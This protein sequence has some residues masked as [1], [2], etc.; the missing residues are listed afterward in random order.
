MDM[1]DN[2]FWFLPD[3]KRTGQLI[4]D[5]RLK[6][7]LT[8]A[9]FADKMGVD[10]K[11]VY[12]WESGTSFPNIDN[13]EVI[14]LDYDITYQE[15]LLPN[16]YENIIDKCEKEEFEYYG[17]EDCFGESGVFDLDNMYEA[18]QSEIKFDENNYP[19]P[20]KSINKEKL[21]EYLKSYKNMLDSAEYA[22]QRK[23][24][25]YDLVSFRQLFD[26]YGLGAVARE[27]DF[28]KFYYN[29]E[30]K[31]GVDYRIKLDNELKN[32]IIYDF[33]KSLLLSNEGLA[34]K[35]FESIEYLFMYK[36]LDCFK[37]YI[38][39]FPPLYREIIYNSLIYAKVDDLP[40]LLD[41][42]ENKGC[43]RY[44]FLEWL[45]NYHDYK[46]NHKMFE[47]YELRN[48][49][50]VRFKQGFEEISYRLKGID[51]KEYDQ[52]RR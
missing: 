29:L 52:H 17:I 39:L 26:S 15:L 43:K 47:N 28:K 49:Q 23:F 41:I 22:I 33:Y 7:N 13:L 3:K 48:S 8:I 20:I 16:G 36:D 46:S 42:F 30:N 12:S 31:Y 6:N 38:E 10:E 21:M 40:E 2:D 34:L 14:H 19:I 11:T 37:A 25:Y 24:F 5:I 50:I 27:Y 45:E 51:Y 32:T 9:E 4:K 44:T 1:Y 18:Y 35:A